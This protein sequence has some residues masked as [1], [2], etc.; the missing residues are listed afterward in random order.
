MRKRS[1]LFL[2]L[3]CL[4]AVSASCNDAVIRDRVVYETE[5]NFMEKASLDQA[6]LLEDWINAHCTCAEGS[7]TTKECRKSA[8]AVVVVRA[9]FPWHKAMSRYNA[10]IDEK[11]P[12][13][14]PPA[15]PDPSTLCP[16][17]SP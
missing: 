11:A 12:P 7:F 1:E 15:I 4:M 8:E 2:G 16:E 13:Q 10:G 9:R 6:A 5:L 17:G 14:D 3:L